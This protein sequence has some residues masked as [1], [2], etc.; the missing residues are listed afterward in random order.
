MLASPRSNTASHAHSAQPPVCQ[1]HITY[2]HVSNHEF[3][4]LGT[5]NVVKIHAHGLQPDIVAFASR[6]VPPPSL[7]AAC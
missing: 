4:L 7:L 2:K 3:Q 5:D 6:Y 1:S